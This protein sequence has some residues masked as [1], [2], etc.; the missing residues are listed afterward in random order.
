MNSLTA[1]ERLRRLL[2]VI[3][4]VVDQDGPLIEEIVER[5]DYSRDELLDDLEHVLFFVGVHPFTP[6]CLIDVTVSEDRVWIQYA[7]WFRRPMRLS[8]AE[9]LQIYAAGRSVV[10]ITGDNHLG[11]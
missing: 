1:L 10:E 2:A 9:M 5:F 11:P 7:D 6:D 8:A 4:W 3:P